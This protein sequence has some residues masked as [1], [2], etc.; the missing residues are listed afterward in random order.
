VC[1]SS[2]GDVNAEVYGQQ[3]FT[4]NFLHLY[5]VSIS[6]T[7]YSRVFC[8]YFGAKKLQSECF[9]FV[10]FGAKILYEKRVCKTLM[11]LTAGMPNCFWQAS[12]E[13]TRRFGPGIKIAPTPNPQIDDDSMDMKLWTSPL[14][15]KFFISIQSRGAH[16]AL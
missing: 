2:S 3:V 1:L 15:E 7:F 12:T 11:K 6:S 16:G 4:N 9:S 10:I 14:E 13:S 5:Q 8:R